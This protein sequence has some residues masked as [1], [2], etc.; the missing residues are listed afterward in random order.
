M[1]GSTPWQIILVHRELASIAG[2]IELERESNISFKEVILCRDRS[3]H[4]KRMLLG[5]GTQFMQQFG[6]INALNYYFPIILE[7][8][9]GMTEFMARVLTGCNATSYAISS[10]LCFWMID[11]FGRRDLMISGS[12]LQ[13]FAY[14][15]VAI[16]VALLANAP[17][18]WGAVAITFLFFYYAAFGCTWGMVP[19]GYRFYIIFACFNLIFIPTVYF[20]YPETANRTLEDLDEYFDRDS[21]NSTIIKHS[22]P[23]TVLAGQPYP[24]QLV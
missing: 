22:N 12:S 6:G 20:L 13:F 9:L 16:S 2:A 8:N 4:L 7:R 19:I 17:T 11:R 18:Q 21:G 14:I 15:M 10:A 5:C 1:Q 23:P 3:G 24:N